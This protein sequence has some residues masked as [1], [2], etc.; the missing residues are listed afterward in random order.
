MMSACKTNPAYSSHLRNSDQ[1]RSQT[2]IEAS[3]NAGTIQPGALLAMKP[4]AAPT[5]IRA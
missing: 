5:C 3:A 1:R 2:M 4:M